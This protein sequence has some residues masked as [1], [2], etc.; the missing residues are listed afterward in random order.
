MLTLKLTSLPDTTLGIYKIK[1]IE[2]RMPARMLLLHPD[3]AAAFNALET[4][5]G[6][7]VYSDIWRSAESSLQARSEKRGVQRPGYSGHNFGISFDCAVDATLKKNKWTYGQ[8]LDACAQHG[9][10][11]FRR[12]RKRGF[13]DWHFNW[14]GDSSPD[15]LAKCSVLTSTWQNAAEMKIVELYGHH[16]TLTPMDIQLCLQKMKMYSGELDGALGPLSNS[17][18]QAFGRAWALPQSEWD[19]KS[20]IFQRTLAFVCSD[21]G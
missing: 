3:A 17:A 5:T 13:E 1:G 10:H 16:F 7:L 8:L 6:G 9:W 21:R 19:A 4:A 15:I 11:N 12:D 18:V 14:L 2:D 20:A